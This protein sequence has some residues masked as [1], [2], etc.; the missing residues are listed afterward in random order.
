MTLNELVDS[1]SKLKGW[2]AVREKGIAGLAI[3][4]A[5]NRKQVIAVSQFEDEGRAMLR[6]TSRIGE[7]D[8]LEQSRLLSALKLNIR[9]PHGCLAVDGTH[10]V[11]TETRPLQ[12]SSPETTGDTLEFMARQADQYERLIYKTDVH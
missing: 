6:F 12:T 3:P 1:V 11:M 4:Q 8:D 9:M 7:T 10:L 2:K 5:G